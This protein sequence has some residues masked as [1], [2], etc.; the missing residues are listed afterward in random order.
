MWLSFHI[1]GNE[2]CRNEVLNRWSIWFC[3]SGRASFSILSEI[4]SGPLAWLEKL[5]KAFL[6][7]DRVMPLKWKEGNSSVTEERG[8]HLGG[9]TGGFE[10]DIKKSLFSSGGAQGFLGQRSPSDQDFWVHAK[11]LLGRKGFGVSFYRNLFELFLVFHWGLDVICGILFYTIWCACVCI[12]DRIVGLFSVGYIGL[13]WSKVLTFERDSLWPAGQTCQGPDSGL[14]W[15][16]KVFR[17]N[18]SSH[19]MQSNLGISGTH[20]VEFGLFC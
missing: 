7:S 6:N 9:A 13:P 20:R 2:D 4:P 16:E 15:G 12:F 14:N 19:K 10:A 17:L 3:V 18:C 8:G 11:F 5:A 1:S